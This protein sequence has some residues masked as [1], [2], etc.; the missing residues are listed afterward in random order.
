MS[1]VYD[2]YITFINFTVCFT[3]CLHYNAQFSHAELVPTFIL[4][5]EFLC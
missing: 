3:K 1:Y 4:E 2:V 5:A